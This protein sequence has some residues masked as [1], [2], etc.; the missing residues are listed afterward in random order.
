M[1]DGDAVQASLDAY[2]VMP[3]NHHSSNRNRERSTRFV[4]I[5]LLYLYISYCWL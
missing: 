2:R 4:H 3:W 1:L 5:F